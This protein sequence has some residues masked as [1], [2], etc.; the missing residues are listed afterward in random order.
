MDTQLSGNR[1]VF[2]QIITAGKDRLVIY[3]KFGKAQ[4]TR[5]MHRT[6]YALYSH[7]TRIGAQEYFALGIADGSIEIE[8]RTDQTVFTGE[9]AECLG[10]RIEDRE[11]VI[12]SY[13]Q[14]ALVILYN[15]LHD[16]VGKSVIGGIRLH[17]S[18]SVF[19]AGIAIQTVAVTAHP[20]LSILSLAERQYL[21]EDSTLRIVEFILMI[22]HS[23][24]ALAMSTRLE[25]D[26]YHSPHTTHQEFALSGY[27]R[28]D[29]AAHILAS[30]ERFNELAALHIIEEETVIGSEPHTIIDR[31]VSQG[32]GKVK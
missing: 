8:L 32:T 7:H 11:S 30:P 12:G 31:I 28:T 6:V 27:Q 9:T 10:L 18:L 21:I 23:E 16:I 20:Y 14:H 29:A 3:Q 1:N 24:I 4:L 19:I 15:T 2:F 5:L 25:V 17:L 13:P 26:L 22:R